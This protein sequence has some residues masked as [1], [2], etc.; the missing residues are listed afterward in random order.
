MLSVTIIRVARIGGGEER[1]GGG[2]G[3]PTALSI[4]Y[5]AWLHIMA[6]SIM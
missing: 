5:P 2:G 1:G 4:G 6:M 3:L